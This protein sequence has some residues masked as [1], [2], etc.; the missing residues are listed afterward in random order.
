M[1]FK[2]E[3]TLMKQETE[4][5]AM[6]HV[7]KRGFTRLRGA[8][9][10]VS[11]S[12]LAGRFAQRIPI[13]DSHGTFAYNGTMLNSTF[14]YF[15]GIGD[16]TERRL[17]SEGITTL[18][19]FS[20]NMPAQLRLFKEMSTPLEESRDALAQEDAEY[21][22]SLLGPKEY[23]RV[24]LSF[25]KDVLFLDIETTGLS[26][27]YDKITVVG[28]SMDGKFNILLSGGDYSKLQDDLGRAKALVTF[29]GTVF[30]LKFLSLAYPDLVFPKAHIDLRYFC[31]RVGMSGGQKAIESEIGVHRET[32]LSEV[33]GENAPVLWH[34]YRR[35]NQEALKRLIEYNHAD[36]EGMKF[37]FDHA[38]RKYLVCN[39]IPDEVI[40]PIC[41]SDLAAPLKFVNGSGKDGIHLPKYRGKIRPIITFQD[42]NAISTLDNLVVIGIDLVSSEERE[43][44]Y[45]VLKS[46]HAE[47]CRVTSDQ[48]MIEMAIANKAD[49]ISIDSPLSIPVGRT[50]FY[51]DD[52]MREKYGITR[53]CERILAKRGVK[54][55]PCLIQSMQKLT[56]RGMELAQKFRKLGIPVIESYPGAAQD[57]MQIPRKQSGLQ[58]LTNGLSEFG[59]E[60][61]FTEELVTHDELD[62]ITSALVGLFFWVGK[63]EALG[64]PDEDYLFIPDIE[65]DSSIWLQRKA[66]GICG[67]IAAGKTT[68]AEYLS[69]KDFEVSRYSKVLEQLLEEKGEVVNRETLQKFGEDIN[70]EKG[71]RWLGRQV[72]ERFNDAK[73]I[74]VDGIRFL[75]DRAFLIEAIG[76]SFKL[77]YVDAPLSA[78]KKRMKGAARE[79]LSLDKAA[80][81]MT[82]SEISQLEKL[83][84]HRVSNSDTMDKLYQTIDNLIGR[85]SQCRVQ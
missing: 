39:E 83:A 62:A 59:I 28:W 65:A 33:L 4:D 74:V 14:L 85:D 13:A 18:E 75:E 56:K 55:Y 29:N 67:H 63:I 50:S 69:S 84:T 66:F 40:P 36:V 79:N 35:G 1:I 24:A 76:P 42:L 15:E 21:F 17:W 10:V 81:S 49:L 30:D 68:I 8:M 27:Y 16:K 5:L 20:H 41:F 7:S 25:P 53:R 71:Q 19:S 82:E 73:Q 80:K 22:A 9:Y 3:P 45:C 31:R 51:D 54:S 78:R 6:S 37:I 2:E 60:G 11:F 38:L 44:G 46:N 77:V 52:P 72:S 70:K 34:E 57:I 48:E 58:H 23:Y 12:G 32:S 64:D 61:D 47:T 26:L 43:S